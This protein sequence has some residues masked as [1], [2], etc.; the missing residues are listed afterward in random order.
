MQ[1]INRGEIYHIS[2][3][4]GIGYEQSGSRPCL[5]ISNNVGNQA[6]GIV[7]VAVITTKIK[8]NIPTHVR[9]AT[10]LDG[11][12]HNFVVM[13]EQIRTVSKERVLS[14]CLG[15]VGKETMKKIDRAYMISC[16][17]DE[18]LDVLLVQKSKECD[19]Q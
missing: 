4:R 5:V 19:R 3:G 16:A 1:S 15:V 6:S 14:H 10:G 9:L 2:L 12:L 17:N 8:R 7:I 13:L 18:T 11:V